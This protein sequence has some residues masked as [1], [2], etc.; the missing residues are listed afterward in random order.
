MRHLSAGGGGTEGGHRSA[1]A[2]PNPG[3][4]A[5]V[6][7]PQGLCTPTSHC[8]LGGLGR[9]GRQTPW[10][11]GIPSAQGSLTE[12]PQAEG[13]G[14]VGPGPPFAWVGGKR[15]QMFM[16]RGFRA[17]LNCAMTRSSAFGVLAVRD[18]ESVPGPR[19]L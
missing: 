17:V 15:S 12:D 8:F 1:R 18:S 4:P 10:K 5:G 16:G 19:G 3:E 2:D 7:P 14:A 6:T 9:R 11:E 13:S